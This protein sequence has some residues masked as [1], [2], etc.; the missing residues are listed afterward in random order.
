MTNSD[1]ESMNKI[2][3]DIL[4]AFGRQEMQKVKEGV[5]ALEA[6]E[7]ASARVQDLRGL[8]AFSE[9]RWSD[10]ENFFKNAIR[11]NPDKKTY[12][13]NLGNLYMGMEKW[14]EAEKIYRTVSDSE[15]S[16][17]PALYNLSMSLAR[18]GKNEEAL[19]VIEKIK[20]FTKDNA[21]VNRLEATIYFSL[22]EYA[23]ALDAADRNIAVDAGNPETFVI[24]GEIFLKTERHQDAALAFERAVQLDPS[25]ID[26]LLSFALSLGHIN[27]FDA[28]MPVF[29]D[30]IRKDPY[31]QTALQG[32]HLIYKLMGDEEKAEEYRKRAKKSAP[33]SNGEYNI[34]G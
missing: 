18:Q 34:A 31:N 10:G 16:Y 12:K 27:R 24:L 6:G 19:S 22:G 30:V 8:I 14:S 2:Y 26:N 13:L 33:V 11:L 3:F 23:K 21:G 28:A 9:K 4:Q 32:L 29:Q 25:N 17:L 7:G 20:E 15:P 1:K 5:A